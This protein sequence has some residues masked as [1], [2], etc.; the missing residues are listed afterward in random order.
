M[1]ALS[2][3]PKRT[4]QYKVEIVPITKEEFLKVYIPELDH[5]MNN[6]YGTPTTRERVEIIANKMY[7]SLKAGTA[8][9]D[10]NA[11][12]R[13]FKKLGIKNTY[14]GIREALGFPEPCKTCGKH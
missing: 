5:A 2:Y 4:N 14:K 9:K 8:N 12:K 7:E 3:I 10:G 11:L 6:E 13:T 1:G